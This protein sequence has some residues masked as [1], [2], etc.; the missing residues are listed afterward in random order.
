[1][2]DVN[3]VKSRLTYAFDMSRNELNGELVLYNNSD[4]GKINN[5]IEIIFEG[6]RTEWENISKSPEWNSS[7]SGNLQVTIHCSDDI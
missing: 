3:A 6:T 1:M 4:K 5:S 7:D 2:A